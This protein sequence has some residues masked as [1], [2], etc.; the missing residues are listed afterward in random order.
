M[1]QRLAALILTLYNR[2]FVNPVASLVFCDFA[3]PTVFHILVTPKVFLLLLD[4]LGAGRLVFTDEGPGVEGVCKP[5]PQ[6]PRCQLPRG[7]EYVL[8]RGSG[9][10]NECPFSFLPLCTLS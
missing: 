6:C 10:V 9:A 3:G 7:W 4:N 2:T 8:G 5:I 1:S